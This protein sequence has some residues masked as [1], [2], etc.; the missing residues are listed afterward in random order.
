MNDQPQV[1]RKPRLSQRQ[2]VF[3]LDGT[4]IGGGNEG[5]GSLGI[6]AEY[7]ALIGTVPLE[8][9]EE[10]MPVLVMIIK[11]GVLVGTLPGGTHPRFEHRSD[12]EV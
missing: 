12:G 3:R 10:V 4:G 1:R 7:P 11:V 9:R 6:I 5:D 2:K 8:H